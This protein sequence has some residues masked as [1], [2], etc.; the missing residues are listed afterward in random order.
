MRHR[1]ASVLAASSIG[2]LAGCT[3]LVAGPEVA[4]T[5]PVAASRDS[6][7]ARARR[8]L[9]S[10]T[11][12]MDVVDSSGGHLT[13]TR[14]PSSSAKLGT[15]DICRVVLAMDISG[16]SREAVVATRTRWVAPRQMA[17]KDSSMCEENRQEVLDRLN[18]SLAPPVQ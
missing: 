13:G 8:G 12:T 7:W 3:Q 18:Q 1:L 11:F 17:E 14:Y 15:P 2:L 9:S 16:D 5:T 10:E 6:T 4:G